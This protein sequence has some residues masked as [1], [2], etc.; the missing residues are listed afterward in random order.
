MLA[1][2]RYLCD[3]QVVSAC[4]T[5]DDLLRTGI[6]ADESEGLNAVT[7]QIGGVKLSI[8]VRET[9]PRK[10][11]ISVRADKGFQ[12]YKIAA[13]YGGGGHASA[14]GAMTEG[15]PAEIRA[16]LEQL[17]TDYLAENAE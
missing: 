6:T 2:L 17:C 9:A 13:V 5:Y 8:I 10:V 15:D 11:R 7:D 12:A 14:A 4:M 3:G 16:H 1:S